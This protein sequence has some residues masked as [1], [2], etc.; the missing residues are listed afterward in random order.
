M[1][2]KN[3]LEEA[4]KLLWQIVDTWNDDDVLEYE[5]TMS[6]DEIVAELQMVKLK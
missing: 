4:L 5:A 2:N 1:T 3:K 6:F